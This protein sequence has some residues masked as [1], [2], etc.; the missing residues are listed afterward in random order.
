MSRIPYVSTCGSL[1]HVLVSTRPN[2]VPADGMVNIFTFNL[3]KTHRHVV[4]SIM[5]DLKG[6]KS[7][8]LCYGKGS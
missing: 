4:K 6:T 1:M 5:Q 2:I 3:G 8:C 7:N